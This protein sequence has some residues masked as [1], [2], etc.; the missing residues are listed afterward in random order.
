MSTSP[1]TSRPVLKTSIPPNVQAENRPFCEAA[2]TANDAS[3]GLGHKGP[4]D[5]GYREWLAQFIE[6]APVKP[7]VMADV[8]PPGIAGDANFA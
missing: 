1:A 3:F 4:T 7:H 2:A 5:P 6:S 8:A